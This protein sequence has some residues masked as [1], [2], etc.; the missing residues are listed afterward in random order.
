MV[1]NKSIGRKDDIESLLYILFYLKTGTLPVVNYID[2]SIDKIR[3]NQF[4]DHVLLYRESNLST[5]NDQ[6]K[7]MCNCSFTSAL[8][9]IS[10]LGYLDKPDYGL[11]R[12]LIA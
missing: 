5:Y 9:Y 1:K 12:F 7:T 2:E 10:H 3:M 8:E 6:V 11:I 4:L